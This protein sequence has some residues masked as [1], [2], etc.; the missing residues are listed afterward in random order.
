MANAKAVLS[1][2]T[3]IVQIE[4]RIA[5][6]DR[7]AAGLLQRERQAA[8]EVAVL[9]GSLDEIG[10]RIRAL[11]TRRALGRQQARLGRLTAQR[12]ELVHAQIRWIL[13]ALQEQAQHT[14]N[15]LDRQLDRLA[16]VQERWE[17]L[18]TTFDALESTIS[19]PAFASLA[20]HWQGQLEIPE[21]P[22]AQDAGYAK[23]FPQQALIF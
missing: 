2:R 12:R 14:R 17:R 9:R 19:G 1:R 3:R 5:R 4:H 7:E 16:P 23:P 15:E 10:P 13:F 18:R 21:F 20:D 8:E 6:L 22:L 11:R